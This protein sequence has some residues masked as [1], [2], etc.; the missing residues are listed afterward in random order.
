M[1]PRR[2][3]LIAH[4]RLRLKHL[5]LIEA[6]GHARNVG[7]AAEE[8]GLTQPAA[9]KILQDAERILGVTLFERRLCTC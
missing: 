3:L 7:R 4:D 8:L 1:P 9:T 2:A 5:R 6:L